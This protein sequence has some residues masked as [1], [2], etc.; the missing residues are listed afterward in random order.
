MG[1]KDTFFSPKQTIT[2]K[3]RLIDF[4]VPKVMGI[5]N[6]T[7]DSFY[8]GGRYT[9][10]KSIL[11]RVQGMVAAG[12]D[13]IDIGAFSTRPGA[14]VITP[15]EERSRLELALKAISRQFPEVLLSVDTFRSDMAKMA[16]ELYGAAVI[17][18]IS[19]GTLDA[20]MM[21]VVGRLKVPYI[22]MH[23]LGTPG[24][25]PLNPQ[26]SDVTR[27]V[28]A[29]FA[30]RTAEAK[31]RGVID[32]IID[33]GFGF[34]K[35]VVQNYQLLRE[36]NLFT[37]MGMPVLA[38]IS[39]KSMIYKTLNVSREDALN[40]TIVANSLALANGAA[41]LRVHDVKEAVEAV[42]IFVHYRGR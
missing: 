1:F 6:V 2:C 16:V 3:G 32:I 34:G 22:M 29:Y 23:M 36:L 18:D 27:D 5:L 7:P 4:T 31:L 14:S 30:D 11:E 21:D 42:K 38:G 39:R 24:H 41:V 8:D 33:P 26:Y 17:N 13:F 28:M 40:G 35:T 19:S 37:M 15:E 10:E 25:M 20:Q 9:D 12:A